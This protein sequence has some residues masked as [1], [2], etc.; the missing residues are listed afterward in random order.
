[1]T[2]CAR[3]SGAAHP[4]T[5]AVYGQGTLICGPCERAFWTW[6]RGWVRPRK[7]KSDFYGAATKWAREQREGT[8]GDQ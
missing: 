3:C 6:L 7:N 1:M 2:R 4:A 8:A 5:G